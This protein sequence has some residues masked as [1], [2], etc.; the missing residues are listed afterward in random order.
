VTSVFDPVAHGTYVDLE[1]F[2]ATWAHFIEFV[3]MLD[4]LWTDGW[5]L[6]HAEDR[7]YVDLGLV[8]LGGEA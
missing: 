5:R 1:S 6:E 4:Q 7:I 8:D 2:G 3:E